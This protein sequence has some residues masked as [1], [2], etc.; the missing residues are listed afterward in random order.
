MCTPRPSLSLVPDYKATVHVVLDDFGKLGRCYRE[1]DEAQADEATIVYQF[2]N[3]E[4]RNPVRV[5]AFN[6]S[7]GWAHDVSQDVARE[8]LRRSQSGGRWI[9]R[10]AQRFL[11]SH[12]GDAF[13]EE[14]DAGTYI[15]VECL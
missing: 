8:G 15:A 10:S 9:A 2:L 12:L 6:I 1:T 5:V 3:G 13:V 14:A 7:E 4:Y 11:A